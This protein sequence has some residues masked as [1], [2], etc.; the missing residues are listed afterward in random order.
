MAD[1]YRRWLMAMAHG[2]G[3]KNEKAEGMN[4]SA[5][6]IRHAISHQQSAIG[7]RASES[8]PYCCCCSVVGLAAKS[9][10]A[11]DDTQLN[12]LRDSMKR[13]AFERAPKTTTATSWLLPWRRSTVARQ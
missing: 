13:P 9:V 5:F 1:G 7:Q 10:D 11:F 12:R 6:T 8:E 2:G 3:G 4:P